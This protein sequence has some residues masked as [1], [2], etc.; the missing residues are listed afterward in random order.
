MREIIQSFP[1]GASHLS[2]PSLSIAEVSM[3]TRFTSTAVPSNTSGMRGQRNPSGGGTGSGYMRPNCFS[4][5]KSTSAADEKTRSSKTGV[6]LIS[7]KDTRSCV[8]SVGSNEKVKGELTKGPIACIRFVRNTL[9]SRNFLALPFVTISNCPD[10]LTGELPQSITSVWRQV[11]LSKKR[12]ILND[13]PGMAH[14]FP[15]WRLPHS[16][17]LSPPIAPVPVTRDGRTATPSNE[18]TG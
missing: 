6:P 4:T 2:R 9:R 16:N 10:N 13:F 3:A 5:P 8:T 7:V 11:G 15:P 12:S 1:A 14:P 17:S 18:G